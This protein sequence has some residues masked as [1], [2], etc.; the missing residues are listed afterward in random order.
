MRIGVAQTR[1]NGLAAWPPGRNHNQRRA[2]PMAGAR[3]GSPSAL[4]PCR[5]AAASPH[6]YAPAGA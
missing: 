4:L 5:G 2:G 3:H 1:D 6:W